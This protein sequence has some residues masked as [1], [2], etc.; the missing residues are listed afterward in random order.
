MM[1]RSDLKKRPS[2][3]SAA[4]EARV[5]EGGKREGLVARDV[6][7]RF[8][9]VAAL[10]EVGIGLAPGAVHG[11]IGPNGAG[12]STL[13]GVLTGLVRPLSGSLYLDGNEIRLRSPADAR[14]RGIVAVPQELAIF[15]DMSVGAVIT[16]GAETTLHGI[17]QGRLTEAAATAALN[18]VG[19]AVSPAV[20]MGVL[21]PSDQKAVMVAQALHR[22]SSVLLL[23]EPTAGMDRVH[24]D[25]VLEV[26]ER[27]REEGRVAILYISHRFD[28]IERLC[29]TVTVMRD[30]SCV[31]MLGEGAVTRGSLLSQMVDSESAQ[32]SVSQ[33]TEGAHG[34]LR[35]RAPGGVLLSVEDLW[36]RRLRGVNFEAK[37]GEV[38]GLA[39]LA[40][41]GVE[42]VFAALSGIWR[43]P[44][45]RIVGATGDV[46]SAKT[47]ARSGIGFLPAAR[48]RAV[49][50]RDDVARNFLLGYRGPGF[51]TFIRRSAEKRLAEPIASRLAVPGVD[52]MMRELSGGNQQKVLIG[53]VLLAGK[54]ILVAEDPT[55]GVDV[56]A[57]K[58]L[59]TLLRQ[60]AADGYGCIIGSTEPE[61]LAEICDRV[62]VFRHGV[63]VAE[64]KSPGLS[65]RGVL[66][67]MTAS[68]ETSN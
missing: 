41:S 3:V 19:L 6:S 8:G 65:T 12:K 59:H 36:G 55:V 1:R 28:E 16:L 14:L 57:R 13:V 64:L 46:T 48:A 53:R 54:R 62:L 27:L 33:R 60:A 30:G 10:R 42:D 9:N 38:L 58:V 21:A 40:G 7:V 61:E 44:R 66:A 63:A 34:P 20:K 22:R 51:R 24:S 47:A 68:D 23:D 67:A 15:R 49:L 5:G 37:A 4:E 50:P 25:K 11:L 43:A 18:R 2:E 45:G 32:P 26:V 56:V 35:G 29:E 39:G 31:G 52:R 17:I